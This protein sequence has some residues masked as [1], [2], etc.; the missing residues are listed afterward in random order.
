MAPGQRRL[1]FGATKHRTDQQ[2]NIS[3][4]VF[5][6]HQSGLV[7]GTPKFFNAEVQNKP[8]LIIG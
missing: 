7:F 6:L 3:I 1:K 2:P 8:N 4:F 5:D